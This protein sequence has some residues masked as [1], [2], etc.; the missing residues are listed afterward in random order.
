MTLN[1]APMVDVMMCLIIFFLLGSTLVDQANRPLNLPYAASAGRSRGEEI[2]NRIVVNVRKRGDDSNQFEY[3]VVAWEGAVKERTLT[4]PE[5]IEYLKIR[6]ERAGDLLDD[7]RC[8]VRADRDVDYSAVEQ[9]LRGC[10]LARIRRVIY[11]ANPYAESA[12]E[13]RP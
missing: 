6:A 10:G 13:V 3:V 7:V 12:A 9:V 4:A 2:G 5:V 8:V 1:L 11:S